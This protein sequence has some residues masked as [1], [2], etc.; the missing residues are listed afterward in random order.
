MRRQ[1]CVDLI[2]R[3]CAADAEVLVALKAMPTLACYGSR[4]RRW[5]G[6]RSFRHCEVN[7]LVGVAEHRIVRQGDA[8]EAP[9]MK[10]PSQRRS[11][12]G[13][14]SSH[15]S[16]CRHRSTPVPIT[17]LP[18][19][20]TAVRR[21]GAGDDDRLGERSAFGRR[22]HDRR[23]REVIAVSTKI[24]SPAR[25]DTRAATPRGFPSADRATCRSWHRCRWPWCIDRRSGTRR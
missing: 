14:R 17:V 9:R 3:Q 11:A 24:V 5:S 2:V 25:S 12:P 16:R 8:I 15:G 1:R 18:R 23:R 7:T 13:S 4:C 19:S 21:W 22:Q 10:T 6:R 20:M